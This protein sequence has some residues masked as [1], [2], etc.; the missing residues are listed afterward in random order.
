MLT[1]DL[2][3]QIAAEHRARRDAVRLV[4]ADHLPRIFGLTPSERY[5]DLVIYQLPMFTDPTRRF[6]E[7]DYPMKS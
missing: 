2:I 3:K 5:L 4:L 7:H 6:D 1:D